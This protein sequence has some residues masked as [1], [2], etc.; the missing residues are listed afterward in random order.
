MKFDLQTGWFYTNTENPQNK[1]NV[2]RIYF[3]KELK[4]QQDMDYRAGERSVESMIK[5]IKKGKK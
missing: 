2:L 5:K 1:K 4:H 3:K